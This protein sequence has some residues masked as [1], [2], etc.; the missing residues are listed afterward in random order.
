ML[1]T[2]DVSG[3]DK[4]ILLMRD[5]SGNDEETITFASRAQGLVYNALNPY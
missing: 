5:V 4:M 2:R 1:L 3:N